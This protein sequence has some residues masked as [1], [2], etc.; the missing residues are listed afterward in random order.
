MIGTWGLNIFELKIFV[1]VF[2]IELRFIII[3]LQNWIFE[4]LFF[5]GIKG[6]LMLIHDL[7]IVI[8]IFF[9]WG[10]SNKDVWFQT[11]PELHCYSCLKLEVFIWVTLCERRSD[12]IFQSQI[13]KKRVLKDYFSHYNVCLFMIQTQL[14]T[15][16]YK[17]ICNYSCKNA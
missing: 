12:F 13:L 17:S 2:F 4:C 7:A 8:L 3:F 15:L 9:Y 16:T 14:I 1:V 5:V 10:D 6:L 11:H